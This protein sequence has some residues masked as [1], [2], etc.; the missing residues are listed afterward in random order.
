MGKEDKGGARDPVPLGAVGALPAFADVGIVLAEAVGR[1]TPDDLL[2]ADHGYTQTDRK[3]ILAHVRLRDMRSIS[4]MAATSL[5]RALRGSDKKRGSSLICA[6]STR[7]SRGF[8]NSDGLSAE[9]C[10]NLL[11]ASTA[12]GALAEAPQIAEALTSLDGLTGNFIDLVLIDIFRHDHALSGLALALLLSSTER[13]APQA[14]DVLRTAWDQLREGQARLPEVPISLTEL[15]A[16]AAAE[17]S[18]AAEAEAQAEAA[19][20]AAAVAVKA[21]APPAKAAAVGNGAAPAVAA[22]PEPR[23]PVAPA[24]AEAAF[25]GTA[26]DGTAFDGTAFDELRAGLERLRASFA[27]AAGSAERV[28]QAYADQRRPAQHDLSALN[29]LAGEF[30][31]LRARV[32][33]ACGGQVTEASADALE[34]VL[35]QAVTAH[36][37]RHRVRALAEV[38]GPS[39]LEALLSEVREGALVGAPGLETLA[40]LISLGGDPD[41]FLERF[42]LQERFRQEA[43][44]HWAPVAGAAA[45]GL[46]TLPD[47]P[48]H[49]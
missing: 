15:R 38:A 42:S 29:G 7:F 25:D 6:L 32:E 9:T 22:E 14:A 11:H 16:I 20:K 30:D 34:E 49:P 33:A 48:P 39:V 1:I 4:K 41:A 26:F 40:D 21:V 17:A 27:A 13:M 43:P 24:A 12:A 36:F 44:D 5:T 19:A 23:S 35:D 3:Q 46:L 18:A 31:D 37:R 45:E 28:R 10:V 8:D 2:S 47:R